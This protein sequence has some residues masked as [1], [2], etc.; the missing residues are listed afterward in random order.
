MG[1]MSLAPDVCSVLPQ[2]DFGSRD[3]EDSI[4][5]K[6]LLTTSLAYDVTRHN[7][8]IV[9]EMLDLNMWP[10]SCP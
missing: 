9:L 5:I 8:G 10:M 7:K 4:N 1:K 3:I 2:W 6:L